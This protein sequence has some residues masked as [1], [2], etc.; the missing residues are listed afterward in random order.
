MRITRGHL[1]SERGAILLHVAISILVLIGLLTFVADWG[2]MWVARNQAQNSADAGA[3]AGAVA[4]AFDAN[5]WTD[6]TD[7]GPA[8]QAAHQLALTNTVF[9]VAPNVLLASDVTFTN[10]PADMCPA[11]ANGLTPCIRVDVYR[12][13]ERNN[14]LPSIFGQAFG[15]TAHGVRATATARVAIADTTNCMKPWA[16]PDKWID[17]YDTT[18]PIETNPPAWTEDDS[19]DLFGGQN[20]NGPPLPNPDV[21]VPPSS[22]SPGSGFTSAPQSQGGDLGR[23]VVLKQGGPSTSISPGVFQPIRL[24]RYDGGSQGGSDYRENISTCTGLPVSIGDTLESENGN[25][26]GPTR[27]GVNDLIALDPNA[28]W[29]PTTNSVINSCATATPSC[30]ASP[31]VV[32][33]PIYNTA[34]YYTTKRQG[35]PTF[36]IV[37]I[38]GFFIERMQGN[39]VVGYLTEAPGLTTGTTPAIDPRAAFLFNIQLIR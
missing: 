24:P 8:K 18:T 11:D 36:V 14:A 4:M 22:T 34:T 16:I 38:L 1:N 9:G 19:F 25:M 37:N 15:I 26:I 13:Q 31:R 7:N 21:Y 29:D 20:G 28:Q 27:Q 10:A 32:P 5:G 17:N 23:R 30:G 33:I 2:V 39:D 3:L 12:N 35:L 6:R